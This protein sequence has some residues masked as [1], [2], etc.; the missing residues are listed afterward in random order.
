LLWNPLVTTMKIWLL[1]LL[2]MILPSS[3]PSVPK[4]SVT[5]FIPKP[6]P[7]TWL[8]SPESP[9]HPKEPEAICQITFTTI[10][11]ELPELIASLHGRRQGLRTSSPC[12]LTKHLLACGTRIIPSSLTNGAKLLCSLWLITQ[13]HSKL[14]R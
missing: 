14:S 6:M 5:T 2:V 11:K 8:P 3:D 7:L 1:L 4:M 9:L 12:L 10:Y 13:L